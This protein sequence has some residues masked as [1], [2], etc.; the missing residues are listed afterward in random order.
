MID[1]LVVYG[2]LV[3]FDEDRAVIEDGALYIGADER[4]AAVAERSDPAPVGF[5][6]ARQLETRGVVYPGLIDLHNHIAY[7]A[8]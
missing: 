4:I 6:S 8:K 1:P 2:R 5:E 3:T 7:R